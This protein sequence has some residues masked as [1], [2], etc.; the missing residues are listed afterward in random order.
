[1][2]NSFLFTAYHFVNFLFHEKSL[3]LFLACKVLL[4]FSLCNWADMIYSPR[5]FFSVVNT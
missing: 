4:R 1:V 5:A 2:I 3:G